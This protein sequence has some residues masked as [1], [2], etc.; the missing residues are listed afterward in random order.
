MCI[1]TAAAKPPNKWS[2]SNQ[3]QLAVGKPYGLKVAPTT[4]YLYS[5][6]VDSVSGVSTLVK[7]PFTMSSNLALRVN[8]VTNRFFAAEGTY[9]GL[10]SHSNGVTFTNAGLLTVKV[11]AKD[12]K[13]STFSGTLDMAGNRKGISGAFGLDGVGTSK[14]VDLG[15]WGH[16]APVVRVHLPL[17]G[18]NATFTGSVSNENGL[19]LSD[20]EGYR[21]VVVTNHTG[22]Y[23]MLVKGV[24]TN[25]ANV[26][27][28]DGYGLVN[29]DAT[30]IIKLGGQLADGQT[31]VQKVTV[32]PQ[33]QWALYSR[34]DSAGGGQFNSFILGWLNV[35]NNGIS[36]PVT[37]VKAASGPTKYAGLGM[38]TTVI[39][40]PYFAAD[41]VTTPV[42]SW[43]N[44]LVTY[45]GAG[46]GAGGVS[47]SVGLSQASGKNKFTTDK[48]NKMTLALTPKSGKLVVT[49][50]NPLDGNGKAKG[51]GAVLT[52]L[53]S[54]R[55]YYLPAGNQRSG[56]F[57]LQGN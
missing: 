4:G 11:K 54:G 1:T 40:S 25:S 8:F 3:V 37:W 44:G 16:G 15:K 2:P 32:S 46:I 33:G 41:P 14:P 52:N 20:A 34:G 7:Y 57:K 9:Y 27:G 56:Q 50:D 47:N 55:G 48:V 51:E 23:T 6:I 10:F 17:D 21:S 39:G 43:T 12:M 31:F 30:G 26:P 18:P 13:Q 19:W 53:N 38:D 24:A 49:F 29:I 28:G 45:E 35:S 22:N 42:L 36:G 5:N